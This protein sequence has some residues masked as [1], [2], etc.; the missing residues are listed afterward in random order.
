MK[1]TPPHLNDF[2]IIFQIIA[3]FL[4]LISTQILAPVLTFGNY[5]EKFKIIS[6]LCSQWHVW[7]RDFSTKSSYFSRTFSE[8]KCRE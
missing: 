7:K 5:L 2:Q 3:L 1:K 4:I 6:L 8:I